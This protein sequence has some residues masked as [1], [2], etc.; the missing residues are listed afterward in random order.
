MLIAVAE[1]ER[2]AGRFPEADE[3]VDLDF[4]LK[5]RL[6]GRWAH[7]YRM[8]FTIDGESVT[9]LRIRH[10]ARDSISDTDL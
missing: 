9:V 2:D 3:S 6:F 7:I 5:E 8:L 10:A 4:E 1:L